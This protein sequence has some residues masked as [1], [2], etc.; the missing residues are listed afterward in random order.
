MADTAASH[1]SS[2]PPNE[3]AS[4]EHH[5]EVVRAGPDRK[6]EDGKL[7]EG[8]E[9]KEKGLRVDGDDDD[10]EHQPPV[11]FTFPRLVRAWFLWLRFCVRVRK[12]VILCWKYGCVI[13][14]VGTYS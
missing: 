6:L 1:A 5:I 7:E 13:P 12:I 10:H 14:K 4:A 3:K 8:N 9:L 11:S 2:T